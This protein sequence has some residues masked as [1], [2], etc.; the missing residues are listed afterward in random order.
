[1][2]KQEMSAAVKVLEFKKN[3][4]YQKYME[5]GYFKIIE[6]VYEHVPGKTGINR[7]ILVSQRG[8]DFIR[9]LIVE[10]IAA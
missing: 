3:E 1:M 4:P 6:Q 2:D 7:K 8:L 9:K 5:R 10:V